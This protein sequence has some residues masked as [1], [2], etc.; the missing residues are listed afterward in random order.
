MSVGGSGCTSGSD[1]TNMA[2]TTWIDKNSPIDV[3]GTISRFCFYTTNAVGYGVKFKIFRVNGS[4]LDFVGQTSIFTIYTDGSNTFEDTPISV[5]SGDYVAITT[6]NYPNT[7]T[8][9]VKSGQA[10]DSYVK[11]GDIV[12]N[13]LIS[14]W[15][16]YS[17]WGLNVYFSVAIGIYVDINKADDTGDGLGWATAKKTMKAG[18]DILNT[19]GTMHVA[20]GNYSAQTGITYNKSWKLSPEDPNITGEKRVTVPPSV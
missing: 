3:N 17:T 12:S 9:A 5:Q 11:S 2:T 4:S 20:S 10:Q 13:S 19:M 16:V 14:S 8:D 15:G 18:W 6:I 1:I 7:N